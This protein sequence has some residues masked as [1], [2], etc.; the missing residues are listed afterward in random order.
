M[1]SCRRELRMAAERR[2][3]VRARPGAGGSPRSRRSL[4]PGGRTEQCPCRGLRLPPGAAGPHG[5]TYRAE[6]P[7]G[8]SAAPARTGTSA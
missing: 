5:A 8:S 1:L 7:G 3:D 2:G 6:A 4:G